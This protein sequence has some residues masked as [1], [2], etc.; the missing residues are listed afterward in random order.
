MLHLYVQMMLLHFQFVVIA[1]VLSTSFFPGTTTTAFAFS[2]ST[3][4]T[5]LISSSGSSVR[6]KTTTTTTQLSVSIGLGPEKQPSNTEKG[7]L[8]AGV[9]YEVPDHDAYRTSRRSTIDEMSDAWFRSLLLSG[10]DN[11]NDNRD[12]GKDETFFL[13]DIAKAARSKLLTPVELKN[14]VR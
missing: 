10:N 2:S 7:I 8:V 13:G 11:D 6:R 14:E 3:S 9:D 1:V 12:D 4:R 5:K